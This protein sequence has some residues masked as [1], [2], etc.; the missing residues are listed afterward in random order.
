MKNGERLYTTPG[1]II[2]NSVIP[3]EVGYINEV[4]AKKGLGNIVA[5]CYKKL[6]ASATANMLDGIK[7]QGFKY[8]TQAG[9]TVSFSDIIVP[10]VYKRQQREIWQRFCSRYRC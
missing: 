1:R 4:V 3:E 10:D 6:G 9:I 2:F 5:K 8:S 7:A